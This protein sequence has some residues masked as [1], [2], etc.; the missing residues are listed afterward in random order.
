[1]DASIWGVQSSGIFGGFLEL[2]SRSF[3]LDTIPLSK[4]KAARRATAAQ[5]PRS[6]GRGVR[7]NGRRSIRATSGETSWQLSGN[8]RAVNGKHLTQLPGGIRAITGGVSAATRAPS[9]ESSRQ[10]PRNIRRNVRRNVRRIIRATSVVLSGQQPG[11]IRLASGQWTGSVRA[12]AGE[13]P[14]PRPVP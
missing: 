12:N 9:G 5:F 4:D 1:M 6:I 3:W 10:F 2:E 11:S 8:F 14:Q 13:C 7:R